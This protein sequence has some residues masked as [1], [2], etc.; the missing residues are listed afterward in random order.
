MVRHAGRDAPYAVSAG[1]IT[2]QVHLVRIHAQM[3][4]GHAD[5]VL[6]EAVGFRPEMQV[7]GVRD[8]AGA[9]VD[10]FGRLV[11]RHLV[12]PLLV[13][14]RRRRAAAAMQGDV[15]GTA[16]RGS[17]AENLPVQFH[18]QLVVLDHFILDGV[19]QR[20]L[21]G[22]HPPTLEEGGIFGGLSFAERRLP[23]QR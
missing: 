21:H 6:I 13:V 10:A 8:A 7:P 22:I 11:E 14:G 19:V 12:P 1:R 23:V 20:K 2:H 18:L 9:E 4:H 16:L 5:H 15:Q 3:G 17:V